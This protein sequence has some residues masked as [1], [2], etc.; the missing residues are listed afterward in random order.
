[1]SMLPIVLHINIMLLSLSH[2]ECWAILPK[3]FDTLVKIFHALISFLF[4]TSHVN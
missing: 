1:M 2:E 4:V 3:K